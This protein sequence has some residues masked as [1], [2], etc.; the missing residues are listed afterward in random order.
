MSKNLLNGQSCTIGLVLVGVCRVEE[1]LLYRIVDKEPSVGG[2][3]VNTGLDTF[4][5]L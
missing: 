3:D 4:N 2:L 1:Y 5:V